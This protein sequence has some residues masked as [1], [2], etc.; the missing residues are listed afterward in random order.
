[1]TRDAAEVFAARALAWLSEDHGRIGAF[2]GWTGM[3]AGALRAGIGDPGLLLAVTDF[4]LLDEAM[5]VAACRDLEVSPLTPMQ[6]R[7]ALPGGED[8]HWT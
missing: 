5:L 3:D 1:M 7:H 2:L 6:A 4:L 8:Y